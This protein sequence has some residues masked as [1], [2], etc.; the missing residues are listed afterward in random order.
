MLIEGIFVH[1][2]T[3]MICFGGLQNIHLREI[4]PTDRKMKKVDV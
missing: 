1:M 4:T 3:F 2:P